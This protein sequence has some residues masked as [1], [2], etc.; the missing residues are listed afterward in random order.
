MIHTT[1]PG[2]N[3]P[4]LHHFSGDGLELHFQDGPIGERGVNGT[5]NEEVIQV[6]IDRIT[7]LNEMHDGKYACAE[8]RWAVKY[9]EMALLELEQRTRARQ[10]RGVEG[11][12]AV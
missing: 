3:S 9:L 4:A 8:N 10:A 7:S 6:L 11:T 1:A 5:T 12:S 2:L